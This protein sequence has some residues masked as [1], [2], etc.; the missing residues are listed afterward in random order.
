MNT[1]C[2]RYIICSAWF[3]DIRIS[4]CYSYF[5]FKAHLIIKRLL[6]MDL[7]KYFKSRRKMWLFIWSHGPLNKQ[8][9]SSSIEEAKKEVDSC[10]KETSKEKKCFSYN[11]AMPEQKVKVAE[12]AAVNGSI[13]IQ[14]IVLPLLKI[15]TAQ[16]NDIFFGMWPTTIPSTLHTVTTYQSLVALSNSLLQETSSPNTGVYIVLYTWW[17]WT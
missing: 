14:W 16:R 15:A 10:Y 12:Y 9:P 11:F 8:D 2:L 4:T 5:S 3:L 17:P 6:F 13:T 1:W 7:F